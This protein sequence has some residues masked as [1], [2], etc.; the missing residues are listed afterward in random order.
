MC[1]SRVKKCKQYVSSM[2]RMHG[3][4]LSTVAVSQGNVNSMEWNDGMERWSGLL[5]CSSGLDHWSAMSTIN[6]NA[7]NTPTLFHCL[8]LRETSEKQIKSLP[9]SKGSYTFN[10]A[11]TQFRLPVELICGCGTPV[12]HS[13]VPFRHSTLPNSHSHFSASIIRQSLALGYM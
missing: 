3:I 1:C 12:V 6:I 9:R 2:R 10:Q 5:E 13:T 7:Y 8:K 4:C 11:L